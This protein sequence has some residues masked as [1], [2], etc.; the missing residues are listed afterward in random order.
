[1]GNN[2]CS[3]NRVKLPEMEN[4]VM[5]ENIVVSSRSNYQM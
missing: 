2:C 3:T 5:E 4:I 1:M